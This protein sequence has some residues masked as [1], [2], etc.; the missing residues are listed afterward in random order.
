MQAMLCY[1]Y[2]GPAGPHIKTTYDS[3]FHHVFSRIIPHRPYTD[4]CMQ[5]DCCLAAC[6]AVLE[7]QDSM[8]NFTTQVT[9][10]LITGIAEVLGSCVGCCVGCH[11]NV[12]LG[13]LV[14]RAE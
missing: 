2:G 5:V 13:L 14:R 1:V 11:P 10:H 8:A 6:Q 12:A 4:G 7:M 9:N 3:L